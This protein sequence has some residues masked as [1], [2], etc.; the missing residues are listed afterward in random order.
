M[1]G[2]RFDQDFWEQLWSKTLREQADK[3]A[4]RPLNAPLMA[5][6]ADVI[7]ARRRRTADV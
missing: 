2:P 4:R 7:R 3:V 6:V 5:E 1:T